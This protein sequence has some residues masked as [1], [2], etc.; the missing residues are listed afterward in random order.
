MY[1]NEL[2]KLQCYRSLCCQRQATA[3]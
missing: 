2:R 3:T 1:M